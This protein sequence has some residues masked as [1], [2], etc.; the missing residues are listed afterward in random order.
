MN[1]LTSRLLVYGDIG[2][3]SILKQLSHAFEE[4]DGGAC[5]PHIKPHIVRSIYDQIKR[6]LDLAT[7]YGFNRNLWQDYLTFVL[8]TNE[9][10]FSLV[11]ERGTKQHGSIE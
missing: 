4:W 3:N 1:D 10:S 11:T 6:L 2:E 9:N 5:D 7:D 8:M